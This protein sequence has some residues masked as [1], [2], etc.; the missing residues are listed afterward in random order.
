MLPVDAMA[1]ADRAPPPP[2]RA[3]APPDLAPSTAPIAHWKLDETAP[4]M[5]AADSSGNGNHGALV[6][7][8]P[9]R[10]WQPGRVGGSL[11]VY[12][13]G[14]KDYAVQVNPSASLDS[15]SGTFTISA[16]IKKDMPRANTRRVVV[17][18]QQG[19]SGEDLLCLA[20][21]D[22]RLEFRGARVGTLRSQGG[23]LPLV[24]DWGHVAATYDGATLRL[25]LN[26][27]EIAALAKTGG[28]IAPQTAQE[29]ERRL[30]IGARI[31]E[32]GLGE[33]MDGFIDDL[34]LYPRAL[35]PDEL[36]TLAQ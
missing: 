26:G 31:G 1:V 9:G 25:Y 32:A 8:E 14:K 23:A 27:A 19:N 28:T 33:P 15:L 3:P 35:A 29:R 6:G 34:R 24:P 30:L 11:Q 7:L 2:D 17:S 10:V 21:Y 16:W 20:F 4:A 22:G 12:S 36:K 5:T 18:R 13:A